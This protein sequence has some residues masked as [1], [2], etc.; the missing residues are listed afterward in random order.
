MIDN[1]QFCLQ[2]YFD[3][4]ILYVYGLRTNK[5][6]WQKIKQSDCLFVSW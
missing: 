6:R 3:I 4:S 5:C 1:F 2:T